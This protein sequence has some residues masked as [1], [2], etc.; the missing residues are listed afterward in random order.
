[1]QQQVLSEHRGDE[2]VVEEIFSAMACLSANCVDNRASF[3]RAGA[4]AAMLKAI[5]KHEKNDSVVEAGFT[6]IANMIQAGVEIATPASEDS[7][8]V[9]QVS[10]RA[11]VDNLLSSEPQSAA[12]I[13]KIV[14]ALVKADGCKVIAKALHRNASEYRIAEMGCK[15]LSDIGLY[16]LAFEMRQ[17]SEAVTSTRLPPRNLKSTSIESITNRPQLGATLKVE[18]AI[19]VPLGQ[20]SAP[21]ALVAVL[22]NFMNDLSVVQWALLSL[23]RIASCNRNIPIL[24]AAGIDAL[25]VL[26]LQ[27][28]FMYHSSV[29]NLSYRL[30]AHFA[31]DDES[32]DV[33]G[34]Q[35][36]GEILLV[37]MAH[38]MSTT[39]PAKL[40]SD[41]ISA[42]CISPQYDAIA[43][44]ASKD[45]FGPSYD[46]LDANQ[47]RTSEKSQNSEAFSKPRSRSNSGEHE[48]GETQTVTRT[49]SS[50]FS[51]Q[52]S[53]APAPAAPTIKSEKTAAIP[54][55]VT[56]FELMSKKGTTDQSAANGGLLGYASGA[57]ISKG[58]TDQEEEMHAARALALSKK[59]NSSILITNGVTTILLTIL[60]MH[61]NTYE[62]QIAAANALNSLALDPV[63]RNELNH[64]SIFDTVMKAFRRC[65][66]PRAKQ[67]SGLDESLH[68]LD[69]SD[70]G[71]PAE[72]T[73]AAATPSGGAVIRS[74]DS[75]DKASA[76]SAVEAE[77]E[78]ESDKPARR[79]L[80]VILSICIGTLC[81]PLAEELEGLTSNHEHYFAAGNQN[82]LGRLHTCELLVEC[83]RIHSRVRVIFT[84]MVTVTQV[85]VALLN[86]LI[87]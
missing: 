21:A 72:G 3:H 60:D 39:L 74:P 31:V 50:L 58:M 85:S 20:S 46:E 52:S 57:F 23:D 61:S 80:M 13:E 62:V 10:S 18:D 73:P 43:V 17:Y 5:S 24:H 27:A 71:V 54:K 41:A 6:A 14:H 38:N 63:H 55:V 56:T 64:E 69:G 33:I 75:A 78:D 15:A 4:E 36:G 86:F 16:G 84:I 68:D 65:L 34:K 1:M 7:S 22:Q 53:T 37:S 45:S 26:V 82:Y 81:L 47:S 51:W 77:L 12:V 25:L 87:L 9:S 2:D 59:S 49:L 19:L 44:M 66:R 35:S 40:G 32:R 70:H 42:L 30:I 11:E 29:V 79:V 28:H 48:A 67:S 8:Q 83:L 76:R